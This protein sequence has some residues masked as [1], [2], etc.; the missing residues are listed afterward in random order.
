MFKVCKLCYILFNMY[1]F[2]TVSIDPKGRIAIPA[3]YRNYL[4]KTNEK[5]ISITKD[6]QYPSLKVYFGSQWEQISN[7]LESLQ[8]LDPVVRKI[9]W[10]ILGNASVNE[11]DPSGRM[12]VNIP[13]ELREYAEINEKNKLCL[14]GMGNKFEIWEHENWSS[15]QNGGPLST[16]ILDIVLPET[17][18]SMSF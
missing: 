3:K 6:P 8:S 1:G 12:L 15:R 10:T 4:E 16:E 11:F 18:K 2:N 5:I 13:I 17:I 7:H 14:V 9:Q